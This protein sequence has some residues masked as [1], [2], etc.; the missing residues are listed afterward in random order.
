MKHSIPSVTLD[1]M[2]KVD[3]LM[4]NSFHISLRQMM[5]NAGRNLAELVIK[6]YPNSKN[7]TCFVGGG[8]N[9][10]GTL[11][12]ARHLKIRGFNVAVHLVSKERNMIHESVAELMTL[13]KMGIKVNDHDRAWEESDLIIDGMVGYNINGKLKASLGNL[14]LT[15]SESGIPIISNDIP[16]GV[17]PDDGYVDKACIH[18]NQTL[19]IALPKKGMMG[20]HLGNLIGDLYLGNIC[21]PENLYS[22]LGIEVPVNLFK[23]ENVI[24]LF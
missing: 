22:E 8:G 2:R 1:Q 5:E 19:T 18:A 24:S 10:A 6:L 4:V 9:G 20:K 16:S 15:L 13:R 21:V 17:H 23:D 3:Q 14:C 12:C 11:V 7:I